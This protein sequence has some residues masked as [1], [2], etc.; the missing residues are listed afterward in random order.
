MKRRAITVPRRAILLSTMGGLFAPVK[1]HA[2]K[3]R[4]IGALLATSPSSPVGAPFWAV[5]LDALR[6]FGWTE[7][8]NLEIVARWTGG[9]PRKIP[10]IA[11][12]LLGEAVELVIA[13]DT[14]SSQAFLQRTRTVPIVM[15]GGADA[16]EAGLVGS[17]AR[18]GGNVTGISDNLH[19]IISKPIDF[20][21][22]FVPDVRRVAVLWNPEN[23]MSTSGFRRFE[24]SAATAGL[25][26]ISAPV[27]TAEQLEAALAALSREP[28]Q[29][30]ILHLPSPI[31]LH[32]ARIADFAIKYRIMAVGFSNHSVRE[33]CLLAYGPDRADSYR[34]TAYYVNRILRGA[35]PADL[36]VEQ[37]TFR[38]TINLKTA[39]ALGLTVPPSILARA[40]EVIE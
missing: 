31:S 25:E 15:M 3:R 26:A 36:P 21:R 34:R 30:L 10:A 35:K 37:A 4:R 14:Q 29:A 7:G 2:E 38:L 12:E 24:T 27:A 40:D 6:A 28:P 23:Q 5:F 19:E 20:M 9:D 33:G 18:P 11:E 1:V 8:N 13:G 39:K 17:L 32:Y 16:V 22:E